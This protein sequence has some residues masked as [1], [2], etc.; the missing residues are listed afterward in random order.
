MKAQELAP[1]E[2][3]GSSFEP[4]TLLPVQFAGRTG[5]RRSHVGEFR[6]MNAILEDAVDMYRKHADAV[7]GRKHDLFDEAEAWIES[8]D[9][10][11]VFS[12]E[13]ICD[14]LDLDADCL[15]AGLRAHKARMRA[16]GQVVVPIRPDVESES[17]PYS[18]ACQ[19]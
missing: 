4:D 14:M 12:F 5:S 13:N 16:A 3:Q 19:R 11:W 8:A 10:Q 15:R 2:A 18:A 17:L 7:R 6:L 1:A 9:R